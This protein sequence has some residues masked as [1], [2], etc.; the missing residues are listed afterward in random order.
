MSGTGAQSSFFIDVQ[1]AVAER[2]IPPDVDW[3]GWIGAA[4]ENCRIERVGNITVR[5]TDEIEMSALN[6]EYREKPGPTNVLSFPGPEASMLPPGSEIEL[7]DIVICLPVALREADVQ[8][9]KPAHHLAHLTIHGALHLV[10]Y[11]HETD[12]DARVMESLEMEILASL[13]IGNPYA[14]PVAGYNQA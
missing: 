1:T 9:K 12:G 5:L 3:R 2:F 10:G 11:D 7:G 6:L 4:L 8:Q 13:G 14:D